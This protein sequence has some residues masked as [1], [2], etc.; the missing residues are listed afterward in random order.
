MF[1]LQFGS[2]S[3]PSVDPLITAELRTLWLGDG[4]RTY[5]QKDTQNEA[6]LWTAARTTSGYG[7][8]ENGGW[9]PIL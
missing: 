9:P 4:L 5:W 1:G 6:T 3:A 7:L 2:R 8:S